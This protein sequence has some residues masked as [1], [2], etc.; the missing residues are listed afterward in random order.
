MERQI[1][2]LSDFALDIAKLYGTCKVLGADDYVTVFCNRDTA[3]NLAAYL[4]LMMMSEV[5]INDL[6]SVAISDE[7]PT[8]VEINGDTI[9]MQELLYENGKPIIGIDSV[10]YYFIDGE[11]SESLINDIVDK[12]LKRWNVD[13]ECRSRIVTLI[14]NGQ[15]ADCQE[16]L[17]AID[18][19]RIIDE[20][21][22]D[23]ESVGTEDLEYL[24]LYYT[25]NGVTHSHTV[26]AHHNLEGMYKLILNCVGDIGLEVFD[27]E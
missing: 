18:V 1:N 21:T 23:E 8:I 5:E 26:S 25:K 24:S 3:L 14:A 20:C 15:T 2:T 6:G 22:G 17:E 13:I 27:D 7:T 19:D 16:D 11:I 10:L 12:N 9:S 4:S